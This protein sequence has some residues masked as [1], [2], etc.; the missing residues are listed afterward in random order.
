[1]V[2]LRTWRPFMTCWERV[3]SSEELMWPS[4]RDVNIFQM[5]RRAEASRSG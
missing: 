2:V 3:E 4:A 1:M 5:E